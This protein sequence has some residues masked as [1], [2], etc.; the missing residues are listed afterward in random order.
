MLHPLSV[1]ESHNDHSY[2]ISDEEQST[3]IKTSVINKDPV[4]PRID[5]TSLLGQAS[6]YHLPKN[7]NKPIDAFTDMACE[8]MAFPTL[9]LLV[10]ME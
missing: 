10:K 6:T 3:S 7:S 9:F 2:S 4:L 1:N 8:Q 5:F